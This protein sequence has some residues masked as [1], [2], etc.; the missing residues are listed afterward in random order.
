MMLPA[1]CQARG[2]RKQ[3]VPRVQEEFLSLCPR[4][5]PSQQEADSL[6]HRCASNPPG[7][8]H[9]AE[10]GVCRGAVW[11]W[12]DGWEGTAYDKLTAAEGTVKDST[13]LM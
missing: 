10:T 9:L 4:Q 6:T 13:A 5:L 8:Q 3:D 12:G 2:R 1:V 7:E 11:M